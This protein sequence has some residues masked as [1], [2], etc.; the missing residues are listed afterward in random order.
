MWLWRLPRIDSPRY[1][2][3]GARLALSS[4]LPSVLRATTACVVHAHAPEGYVMVHV[5][6]MG[7]ERSA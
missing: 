6:E 3:R 5:A 4:R 1:S 2:V 7:V